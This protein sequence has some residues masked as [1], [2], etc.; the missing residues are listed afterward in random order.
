MTALDQVVVVEK[1]AITNAGRRL[2]ELMDCEHTGLT[3]EAA[4]TAISQAVSLGRAI[5]AAFAEC[6]P[7]DWDGIAAVTIR[8]MKEMV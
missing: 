2:I 1:I 5:Q 4:L 7:N 8:K 6:K 3:P